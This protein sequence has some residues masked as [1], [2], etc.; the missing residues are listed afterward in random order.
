MVDNLLFHDLLLIGLLWLGGILYKRW[1]RDRAA[2]GPTSRKPATPLPKHSQDPKPFLGLTHK[3]CCALCEQTPEPASPVPLV[4][5]APLPSSSGRPRQVDTTKQ[6]C[7]Q[8]PCAYYGWTGRGNLRANG[9][10]NG[11]RW[12]QF[13]CL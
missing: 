11:G 6:F 2:T 9:Y 8:P 7:P 13:Q 12:H 4:P 3:P 1:A 5:P 10:P